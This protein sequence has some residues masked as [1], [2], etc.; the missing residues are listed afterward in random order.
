M[1]LT[2]LQPAQKKAR[3]ILIKVSYRR[4]LPHLGSSLSSIDIIDAI[5]RI[6]TKSERFVLSNGHAAMALYAVL[7]TRGIITLADIEKLHTHPDRNTDLGIEVSTGSLGQG[8]PIAL[9]MALADGTRRVFCVISDGECA[10]GSIWESF[11]VL[12]DKKISNLITVVNANGWGAYDPVSLPELSRRIRGFGFKVLKTD[13]HNTNAL[14]TAIQTAGNNGPSVIFAKTNV[15]QF[16]FLKDQDA[17]YYV[18]NESD[19]ALAMNI[20]K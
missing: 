7:H 14:I 4:R 13:G 10:E 20:L 9:G 6:K 17:H 11:K 2:R 1:D 8:L 3:K 15:G 18:M 16:P 12:S 19:Y 5:Y